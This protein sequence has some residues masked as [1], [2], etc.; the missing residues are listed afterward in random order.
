M[1]SELYATTVQRPVWPD[2]VKFQGFGNVSK[3]LFIITPNFEPTYWAQF[4]CYL[5]DFKIKW[6]DY[7]NFSCLEESKFCLINREIF[8]SV[9][10]ISDNFS[11]WLSTIIFCCLQLLKKNLLHYY[12]LL[13]L[14]IPLLYL[15]WSSKNLSISHSNSLFSHTVLII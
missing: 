5:L 4:L 7:S 15:L 11:H 10:K 2:F 14:I 8:G 12:I 13:T 9:W 1:S 6:P 3:C